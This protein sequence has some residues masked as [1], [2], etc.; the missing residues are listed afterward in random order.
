[1]LQNNHFTVKN[2]TG[3]SLNNIRISFA[4]DT[5]EQRSLA[6][7]DSLSFQPW[8]DHDGGISLSYMASGKRFD[9]VLGYVA[10]PIS[11]TCEFSVI[12]DKV[13]GDCAQN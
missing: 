1:M 2:E 10:P 11:M 9:H 8:P 4:D 6:P 5:F 7:G 3:Q 13:Q 12:G